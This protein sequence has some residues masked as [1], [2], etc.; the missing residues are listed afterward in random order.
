MVPAISKPSIPPN[1][2]SRRIKNVVCSK[3]SSPARDLGGNGEWPRQSRQKVALALLVHNC[4]SDRS[5][6]Y[7]QNQTRS[8]TFKRV[9]L[10]I[11]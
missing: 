1:P 11:L 8:L 6:N 2:H 7:T 3:E 4:L 5:F 9:T 10:T